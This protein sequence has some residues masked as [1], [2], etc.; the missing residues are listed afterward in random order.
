[1]SMLKGK[2]E[3]QNKDKYVVETTEAYLMKLNS[4]KAHEVEKDL[5][6]FY[7]NALTH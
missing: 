6:L 1:M 2:P 3:Q 5:L 7:T 4:T